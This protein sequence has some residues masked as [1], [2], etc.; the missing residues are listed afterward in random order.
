VHPTL[1]VALI[2]LATPF[3]TPSGFT[4]RA[5]YD[6]TPASIVGKGVT[7]YGAGN[8]VTADAAPD[9]YEIAA[10]QAPF[11]VTAV[12]PAGDGYT[13][14]GS[15]GAA[16][17]AG[18]EGGGTLYSDAYYT[19]LAGIHVRAAN[20][21]FYDLSSQTFHAWVTEQIEGTATYPNQFLATSPDGLVQAGTTAE[22]TW[23]PCAGG[24]YTWTATYDLGTDASG[25]ISAG[26][27]TTKLAGVAV[28]LPPGG[29]NPGASPPASAHGS[30]AMTIQIATT[31]SEVPGIIDLSAVCDVPAV[32]CANNE[33]ALNGAA[34]PTPAK[35]TWAPCGSECF[36]WGAI[37]VQ[38]GDAISV[39]GVSSTG[40]T[41]GA[42]GS[43]SV[44]ATYGAST[45]ARPPVD[46]WAVC[47]GCDDES[48]T[49]ATAPDGHARCGSHADNCG[50][51]FDCGNPCAGAQ[52]CSGGECA[53]PPNWTTNANLT[54]NPPNPCGTNNG[55]C[56]ANAT[57]TN[58]A[59]ND[60]S[61]TCA[62]N[63]DYLGDGYT[64]CILDECAISACSAH[65][66][67]LLSAGIYQCI[68]D[69]AYDQVAG[70]CIDKCLDGDSGCPAGDTCTN[71]ET[72]V[73]CADACNNSCS[74]ARHLVCDTSTRSCECAS[75]YAGDAASGCT[76][77]PACPCGGV[78]G[79][80][81]IVCPPGVE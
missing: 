47:G 21:S 73:S 66:T 18:D 78:P 63:P 1:N 39:A 20:G 41:P 19:Y 53:C 34:T 30:G 17:V 56:A 5:L 57:C 58:D 50:L 59:N 77:L 12:T 25:S 31:A 40:S 22:E 76:K 72:Y 54:C 52:V 3:E 33:C 80:C 4:A 45:T 15:G 14:A 70:G 61:R 11:T 79:H 60:G 49:C 35:G 68:C 81:K 7:A 2:E 64:S 46:L 51:S 67:C 48:K 26:G 38:S 43:V 75:G 10:R 28:A 36:S 24:G 44:Q 16:L 9:I 23:A 37:G 65:Q 74:I 62:C 6:A 42:C 55:G 71:H 27:V 8:D 69:G 29:S 32:T 13:L